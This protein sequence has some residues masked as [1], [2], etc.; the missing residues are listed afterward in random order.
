MKSVAATNNPPLGAGP[1]SHP[2]CAF[3]REGRPLVPEEETYAVCSVVTPGY[4]QTMGIPLRAGRSFNWQ[5]DKDDA[6]PVAMINRALAKRFGSADGAIGRNLTLWRSEEFPRRIVGVVENAVST[7]RETPVPAMIYLPYSQ[8]PVPSLTLFIRTAT[9]PTSLV[10]AV[11]REVRSVDPNLPLYQIFTMDQLLARSISERLFLSL[12]LAV[13]AAIACF[14]AI[15][16]IY[17]LMRYVATQRI[18]EIG[19]RM[20][21]G[22]PRRGVARLLLREAFFLVMLGL[23]SG[24]PFAWLLRDILRTLLF[25][26]SPT[27]LT[28]SI[29]TSFVLTVTGLFASYLPIRQA[30]SM[31]PVVAL[32][33]E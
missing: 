33:Y 8:A 12:L 19:I 3:I 21:L 16:G 30:T 7:S 24:I 22:A 29:L 25:E 23:V 10:G 1:Y 5:D 4:F 13:F 18:R 26:V 27:D 17:G 11:R 2:D 9:E 31:D 28:I 20:A 15:A 14:L 32:R 6:V